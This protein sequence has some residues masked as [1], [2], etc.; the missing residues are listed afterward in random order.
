V[1][2]NVSPEPTFQI[3]VKS[4]FYEEEFP[5]EDFVMELTSGIE[6]T[7]S[8]ITSQMLFRVDRIPYYLHKKLI[9]V[10]EH[11]TVLINGAYWTKQDKYEMLDNQKETTSMKKGQV[12]LTMR[13]FVQRS[14]L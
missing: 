4:I 6:K 8:V 10:F 7:S 5:Q 9:L 14:V 1:Y 12:L 3:R 13:D 11:Q 2:T